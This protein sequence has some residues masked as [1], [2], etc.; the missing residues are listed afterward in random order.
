MVDEAD[1]A[2]TLTPDQLRRAVRIVH[3]CWVAYQLATYQPY[4]EEP[5]DDQIANT[6]AALLAYLDD[7]TI[8]VESLHE[9]WV[10]ERLAQGWRFGPVFNSMAKTHPNLVPYSYLP[11]IER[12][13]NNNFHAAALFAV[14][15]VRE[16]SGS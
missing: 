11:E 12:R 15:F 16:E 5:T 9:R 6:E 13:K 7:P 14:A 3:A 4:N 10:Q 8:R 1:V 2:T